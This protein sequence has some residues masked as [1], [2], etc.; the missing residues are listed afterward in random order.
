MQEI[1]L[2]PDAETRIVVF[3]RFG[4]KT[5]IEINGEIEWATESE[6]N[7]VREWANVLRR[8]TPNNQTSWAAEVDTATGG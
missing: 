8:D 3:E 5:L 4:D 2:I 7:E 1:I 6:L